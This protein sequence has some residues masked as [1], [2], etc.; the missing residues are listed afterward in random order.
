MTRELIPAPFN[1]TDTN[2]DYVTEILERENI[3]FV[4]P[5]GWHYAGFFEGEAFYIRVY[6]NVINIT[7][8]D[9]CIAERLCKLFMQKEL[10]GDTHIARMTI[11]EK[12][13][14]VAMFYRPDDVPPIYENDDLIC[15]VAFL[16]PLLNYDMPFIFELN[17][18]KLKVEKYRDYE[19]FGDEKIFYDSLSVT[20]L[21]YEHDEEDMCEF[22]CR[23]LD[24][25]DEN[26]LRNKNK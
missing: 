7:P 26:D 11:H 22:N 13:A 9:M 15:V 4:S 21:S 5:D 25:M 19:G 3:A 16:A 10:L 12:Y 1:D 20:D 17:E 2:M 14:S 18:Y 23:V 6:R 8:R 24:C